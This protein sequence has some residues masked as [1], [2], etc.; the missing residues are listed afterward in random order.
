[1]EKRLI[2][3]K[4]SFIGKEL[5]KFENFDIVAY[6][7][8]HHVDF[9]KYSCVVNCALD[10]TFK[11]QPYDQENDVD[12][13]MAKLSYENGCHYVMMSTRKV[14]GS[15]ADLRIFT[16]K[17]QTNPF[18]FYSENK[19]I[20]EFKIQKDFADK[21]VIV[22]GSNLFGFEFGRQSFMGFC[23]NQ[24]KSKNRI[25]FSISENIKRD[26]IDIETSCMML[27][28]ISK[29]KLTG[30]YNLSSNIGLEI[31]KVAKHL[32]NGYGQG[33]FICESGTIKEQ[34][35]VDNTKLLKELNITQQPFYITETIEKLGEELARY[36]Y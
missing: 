29:K 2:I 21:S 9:S 30:I 31:G 14:Y 6:H 33:E 10:P 26:F 8:I 16:E 22:R 1:M 3:G 32:I 17:S 34:F 15:Y 36:D 27:D 19:L 11:T 18:D 23:M 25:I 4:T 35:I 28:K 7:N 12:Y 24:L 5:A 13:N 20:S